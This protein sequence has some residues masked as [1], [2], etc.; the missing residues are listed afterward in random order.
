MPMTVGVPSQGTSTAA[1]AAS[2]APGLALRT[3]TD[4]VFP[5][6]VDVQAAWITYSCPARALPPRVVAPEGWPSLLESTLRDSSPATV[7]GGF[8]RFGGMPV[9]V[10]SEEAG[11]GPFALPGE[12]AGFGSGA[13]RSVHPVLVTTASAARSMAAC[14]DLGMNG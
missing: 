6:V 10:V 11:D 8:S 4:S 13:G 9:A 5:G 1:S 12:A 14:C 3:S 2:E 7:G